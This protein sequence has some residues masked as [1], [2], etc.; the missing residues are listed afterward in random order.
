[1]KLTLDLM[2]AFVRCRYK[3]FL[4][5]TG[6]A[7]FHTDYELL[8]NRQ[9]DV[10]QEKAIRRLAERF[11][12]RE[13]TH[14]PLSLEDALK[15]RRRLIVN[16]SSM[17]EHGSITIPAIE[18]LASGR[19]Q[20]YAVLMFSPGNKV[21][22]PTKFLAALLGT[23]LRTWTGLPVSCAKV[24][25]GPR[26]SATR[27]GLSGPH[28]LTHLGKEAR[29]TFHDLE[30][31]VT[32][33]EAPKLFLNAHCSICEYR[34]Q[35]RKDAIEKENLSLLTGLQS[36]EI[37]AWN[38][39]GI[40]TVTQLAHTFRPKTMGRSSVRPKRHSQQLQAM[41]IRDKTTYIRK[42]PDMP[43]T[44]TRVFVDV[45]GIP[46]TGLFYLIGA[47]VAEGTDQNSYQFW[48]D[49]ES[50]QEAMWRDFLGSPVPL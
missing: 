24:V 16:V 29:T 12:P 28:G 5:C 37:E 40:F 46:D 34:K 47:V 23:A 8:E 4:K 22:R 50:D 15:G 6:Q 19:Q 33:P 25:F 17:D 39:R 38:E 30:K 35:C 41:A 13:V 20:D 43:A 9:A 7:G 11:S 48:A 14:G 42:R 49:A 18:R 1:M 31:M 10:Y 44:T 21:T 26:F 2:D 45:E 36:K 32:T 27:L 3:A